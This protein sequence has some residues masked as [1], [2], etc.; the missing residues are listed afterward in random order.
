MFRE[1]DYCD[2][3]YEMHP[4]L[5]CKLWWC[6]TWRNKIGSTRVCKFSYVSGVSWVAII[7]G[8]LPGFERFVCDTSCGNATFELSLRNKRKILI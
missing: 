1:G 3:E 5:C 2:S 4:V 6:V 7:L 8:L